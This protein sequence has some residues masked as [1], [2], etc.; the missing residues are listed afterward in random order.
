MRF[1]YKILHLL[2]FG[3]SGA[4]RKPGAGFNS[5]VGMRQRQASIQNYNLF[6]LD[7]ITL[8]LYFALIIGIAWW[9]MERD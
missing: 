4:I 1:R 3:S 9:V 7:W 8:S 2:V 6:K 5:E